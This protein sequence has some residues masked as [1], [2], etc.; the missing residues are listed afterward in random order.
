MTYI[1]SGGA[2][3]LRPAHLADF[4][5]AAWSTYHFLDIAV[6]QDH[7][8]VHAIDQQLGVIDEVEIAP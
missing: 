3:R 6:W 1:V 8:D 5:V 2:A 7:L 4:S